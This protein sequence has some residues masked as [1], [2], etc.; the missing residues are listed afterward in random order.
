MVIEPFNFNH[1]VFLLK[2]QVNIYIIP[3]LYKLLYFTPFPLF[4]ETSMETWNDSHSLHPPPPPLRL[5]RAVRP[6]I[7][8]P[9]PLTKTFS[10]TRTNLVHQSHCLSHKKHHS[11]PVSDVTTTA[12]AP[13]VRGYL[14][15][16][17]FTPVASDSGTPA[18]AP[19]SPH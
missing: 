1:T 17:V 2:L 8:A 13:I 10:R 7:R 11:C 12:S 3:L 6:C 19:P 14:A 9:L 15:M 18:S 5:L 16:K 4:C